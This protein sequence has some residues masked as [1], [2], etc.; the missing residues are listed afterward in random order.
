MDM[1]YCK[2]LLIVG[3]SFC[4]FRTHQYHWPQIVM[5]SLTDKP[6]DSNVIPRGYG[7][8]G[9]SWWSVRKH[10]LDQL[11][12]HVPKVAVFCHTEPHR[13]PNPFDWGVNSRSAE[14]G[15]VHQLEESDKLMPVDYATAARLYYEQLWMED[16]H[17]WAVEQWFKELDEQT[18]QIE[19][20]QQLY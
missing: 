6:Y 2:D 20:V 14:I 15:I 8:P 4:S 3:D 11:N 10:F 19:K 9:A 18:S 7:F 1:M 16:Y 17:H 13:L 5:Q 12:I